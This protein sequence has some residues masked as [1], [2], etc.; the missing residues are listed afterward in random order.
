MALAICLE[1]LP[2]TRRDKFP[3][4]APAPGL[5]PPRGAMVI[6]RQEGGFAASPRSS[7]WGLCGSL[8]FCCLPTPPSINIQ[9]K[10]EGIVNKTSVLKWDTDASGGKF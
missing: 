2:W 3:L 5:R 6:S 10:K 7:A 1:R 9:S 8:H 4:G